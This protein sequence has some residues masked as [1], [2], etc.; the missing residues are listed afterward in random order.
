M[1]SKLISWALEVLFLNISFFP[2]LKILFILERERVS[3]GKS[4]WGEGE[5]R[6]RKKVKQALLSAW[7]LNVTPF[8]HP[9]LRT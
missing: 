7:V 4:K 8:L 9:E 6:G 2:S 1:K 5:R 3:V